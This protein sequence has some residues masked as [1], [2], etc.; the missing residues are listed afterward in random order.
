MRI[1]ERDGYLCQECRRQGILKAVG[2]VK[3]S[4]FVDHIVPKCDGG[5]DDDS[6]DDDD[7]GSNDIDFNINFASPANY[8]ELSD[9]ACGGSMQVE[10][11]SGGSALTCNWG[12]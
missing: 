5:S 11:V 2:D 1:L 10:A 3:Y 6:S 7:S 8:A 12:C 4:A 9:E